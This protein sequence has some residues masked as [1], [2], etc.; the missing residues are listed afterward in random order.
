MGPFLP[1]LFGGAIKSRKTTTKKQSELT[2]Q[3]LKQSFTSYIAEYS[4]QT[5]WN[6][7][8]LYLLK[9]ELL[10]EKMDHFN[11]LQKN[12]WKDGWKKLWSE[13]FSSLEKWLF[14]SKQYQNNKKHPLK[15]LP[16]N[17]SAMAINKGTES[18]ISNNRKIKIGLGRGDAIRLIHVVMEQSL[19]CKFVWVLCLKG[20]L[21]FFFS[22]WMNLQ[23]CHCICITELFF[24]IFLL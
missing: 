24:F 9:K 16:P 8:K 19:H 17:N 13:S 5:T 3:F 10:I 22:Y 4:K 12:W 11:M 20:S 21:S 23:L 18:T 7:K 14:I 15:T 1:R 2:I 6:L